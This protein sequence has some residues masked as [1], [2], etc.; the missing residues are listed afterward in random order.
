MPL[1]YCLTCAAPYGDE[2]TDLWTGEERG[3]EPPKDASQ[4]REIMS[5]Q[6]LVRRWTRRVV[7]VEPV[8]I[9]LFVPILL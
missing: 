5:H 9:G 8:V 2:Q 4:A 3:T 6:Q 1:V 7:G